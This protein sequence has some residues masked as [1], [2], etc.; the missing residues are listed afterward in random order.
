MHSR[1]RCPNLVEE[2]HQSEQIWIFDECVRR[3][4]RTGQEQVSELISGHSS[5]YVVSILTKKGMTA[6]RHATP[7]MMLPATP[8]PNAENI[9]CVYN[10]AAAAMAERA[11]V[12][13][14]S[15]LAAYIKYVSVKK[16]R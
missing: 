6:S 12:F 11:I 4:D 1:R 9:C 13:P 10:G 14:A 5:Y 7:P 16:L 8:T 15:A 3:I 2:S